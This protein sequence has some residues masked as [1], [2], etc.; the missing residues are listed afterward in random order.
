MAQ[1]EQMISFRVC[2]QRSAIASKGFWFKE[3]P[4]DYAFPATLVQIV[5]VVVTSRLL[6]FLLKPLGQTK[7]SCDLLGGFI[8]G[9][10]LLGRNQVIRDKLFNPKHASLWATMGLL[11]ATYSMFITAVKFDISM[12]KGTKHSLKIGVPGFFITVAVSLGLGYPL[13]TYIAG[14]KG[15]FFPIFLFS[16][17]SFTFF[18][19]IA[20]ALEDLNLMNS[21]LGQI[22][23]SSALHFEMIQWLFSTVQDI[24][25]KDKAIHGALTFISA[26]VLLVFIVYVI[27]P[28]MVSIAKNTP[29]GQQVK[30]FYVVAIL[31]GALVLSFISDAIGCTFVLGPVILGFVIPDGPPLGATLI[32]KTELLVS[33]L[34]LPVFF[35]RIGF[36]INILSISDWKSFTTLQAIIGASYVAKMVAVTGAALCCKISLRN[37]LLL[38]I[39]LNIRGI[40]DLTLFSRWRYSQLLNEHVYTQLVLSVLIGNMIATSLVHFTY[41]PHLRLGPSPKGP[42]I[43]NIQSVQSNSPFDILC[44]I[45][46]EES[47]RNL[48]SLL[49][50]SNPTEASPICAYIIQAVELVGRAVPVLV[51]YKK[52]KEGNKFY[53]INSLTHHMMQAFLNYSENSSGPVLIQSFTMI[54]PYKSM[55][56]TICRLVDDN[57]VPLVIL[58]FHENHQVMVDTNV[59][60]SIRQF[61]N[62][63][64]EYSSCTVGI[65]V[66]RGLPGRLTMSHFSY[67]VATFFIG[68]PDDREALALAARMLGNQNVV[69]TVYKF[70][71]RKKLSE[72]NYNEDEEMETGLDES[73][74]DEFKLRNNGNDGLNWR[75]IEV[76]DSIQLIDAIMNSQGDYDLLM[77]GRRHANSSLRDE[78][79]SEFVHYAELGMIGDMLASSDFCGGMVNVLVLQESKEL[80]RN[81]GSAFRKIWE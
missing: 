57:L 42:R 61:N 3:N 71:V 41:R 80:S 78:E 24:A 62:N 60:A 54:A 52:K 26:V 56:E 17:I 34:L 14:I 27:R 48:T 25:T 39:I 50:A 16:I 72:G 51:P 53:R 32:T 21:E 29:E 33:E 1:Y 59:T 37:S 45:H 23:M 30:E 9:P 74:V 11:G 69:L 63:V 40:I 75:D 6:Y 36:R 67:N 35:F 66:E 7:F 73:M 10:S 12:I 15:G 46:N 76:E 70:I 20:P 43:R 38:G 68:G 22:A 5:L 13:A 77:V 31:V 79:M 58:P 4:L 65:L 8:L 49:E 19:D 81:Y 2:E 47:I 64:Q 44:C 55:H 18:P 28:L